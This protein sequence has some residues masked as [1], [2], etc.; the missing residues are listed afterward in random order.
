MEILTFPNE[1]LRRKSKEV[2]LTNDL[3]KKELISDVHK[4]TEL[5]YE[6][7]G[8]GLAAPQVG[9]AKRF[10]IIDVEQT[11]ERDEDDNVVARKK[12]HL[13]VFI[14]PTIVSKE[15]DVLYEEGCLSV[16]GIYEDVKKAQKLTVEYYDDNFEKKQMIAEGLMAIAIQHENDHLDGKL[17]ID[18]LSVVKRT[19]IKNKISKGK[20]F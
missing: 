15:G 11:V 4:M 8:I 1:L 3:E 9:I 6:S 20:T 19:M 5:M 16:P 18:K 13:H 12:G 17:F 10:F 2:E 14:N 7:N